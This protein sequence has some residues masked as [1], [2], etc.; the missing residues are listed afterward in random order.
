MNY[1]EA[2]T[3]NMSVKTIAIIGAVFT[4][5]SLFLKN[6]QLT[7]KIALFFVLMGMLGLWESRTSK[8]ECASPNS[9]FNS[10]AHRVYFLYL[11]AVL[12]AVV[13]FAVA[14]IFYL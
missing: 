1:K 8:K 3:K 6:P 10:K 14:A 5:S 9:S 13:I 12:F 11:V 4:I 7:F 2:L